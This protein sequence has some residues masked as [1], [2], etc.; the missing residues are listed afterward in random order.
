MSKNFSSV[1]VPIVVCALVQLSCEF[2]KLLVSFLETLNVTNAGCICL[3]KP[4]EI[5][6]V[7]EDSERSIE[8]IVKTVFSQDAIPG[9][10]TR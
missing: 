7:L 8:D 9:Q 6:P 2:E 4:A 5:S 1:R 10:W 3:S